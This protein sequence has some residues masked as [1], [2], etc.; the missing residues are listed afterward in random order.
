[1]KTTLSLG[2]PKD[3]YPC[4]KKPSGLQGHNNYIVLFTEPKK[5]TVV[6]AGLDAINPLGCYYYEWDERAFEVLPPG[7]KITIEV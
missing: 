3:S 2:I 1:M 4:L 6:Y 7:S 5:G